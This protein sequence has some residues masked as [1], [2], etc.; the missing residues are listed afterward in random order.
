MV[1]Q[2]D[3]LK[4]MNTESGAPNI[5][6]AFA[7]FC[8]REGH[9]NDGPLDEDPRATQFDCGQEGSES[10]GRYPTNSD[11]GGRARRRLVA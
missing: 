3:E 8:D 4:V 7:K 11:R 9:P 5:K 6:V 1:T 2:N 10:N